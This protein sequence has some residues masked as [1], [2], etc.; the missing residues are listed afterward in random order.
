MAARSI[1]IVE[2]DADSRVMLAAMLAAHGY[3]AALAADGAEGLLHARQSPPC[4]ILLDLMMPVMDG[5]TFRAQQLAD[6]A[7]ASIPVMVISG[8]HNARTL[9]T[10]LGAIGV[11]AKPI[12]MEA[13]LDV[14]RKHCDAG[15]GAGPPG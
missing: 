10:E 3:T 7:L 2:D 15:A 8:R 4:L 5:A 9:A 12:V 1:L 13:L 11:M 14:V 6:P